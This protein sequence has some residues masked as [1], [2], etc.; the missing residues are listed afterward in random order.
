MSQAF[1]KQPLA[2]SGIAL[3][4]V[5]GQEHLSLMVLWPRHAGSPSLVQNGVCRDTMLVPQ[6]GGG[7]K[8][9]LGTGMLEHC[10]PCCALIT[11]LL[12]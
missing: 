1:P 11:L 2:K 8:P 9:S 3:L 6:G 7:E 4:C 12:K 10:R 5:L